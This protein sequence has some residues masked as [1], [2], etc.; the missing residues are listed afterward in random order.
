MFKRYPCSQERSINCAF[1]TEFYTFTSYCTTGQKLFQTVLEITAIKWIKTQKEV[2]T[3]FLPLAPS[4]TIQ[5][6]F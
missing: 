6:F 2:D 4:I 5:L 3:F 1:P